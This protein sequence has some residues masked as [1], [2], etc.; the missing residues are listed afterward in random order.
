MLQIRNTQACNSRAG[1]KTLHL[2]VSFPAGERP[3]DRQLH[4]IEDALCAALGMA[5]HQRL[6]ALHVNTDHAHLHVALIRALA[7][8]A[9]GLYGG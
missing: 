8:W 3:N 6:S 1:N 5:E 2:V 9:V 4:Q 7:A